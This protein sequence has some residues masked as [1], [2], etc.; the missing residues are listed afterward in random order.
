MSQRVLAFYASVL[1]FNVCDSSAQDV[2]AVEKSSEQ[3]RQ[4]LEDSVLQQVV[5]TGSRLT[6]PGLTAPTPVSVLSAE[7]LQQLNPG[8]ILDALNQ[9][10]VLK[11]SSSTSGGRGGGASRRGQNTPDLRGLGPQETLVLLDGRRMVPRNGDGYVDTNVIPTSLVS[12]VE[13]VTGGASAAYGAD[14]VAGV[15]NFILNED[16]KGIRTSIHAQESERG[17]QTQYNAG[18]A[19]GGRFADGRANL[20]LGIDATKIE[21]TGNIYTNPW[22][23]NEAG[24]IVLGNNR[25]AGLPSQVMSPNVEYSQFTPGGLILSGGTLVGTAFGR[26]GNL[27]QFQGGAL[28]G[29]ALMIGPGNY[30]NGPSSVLNLSIPLERFAG[31]TKLTYELAD[32]TKAW[33]QAGYNYAASTG[34][35]ILNHTTNS[36]IVD[37]DNPYLPG[38]LREAMVSEGLQTFRM[39]RVN[40]DAGAIDSD[41]Y[42]HGYTVAGGLD[43]GFGGD[44]YWDASVQHN[45][46]DWKN[47]ARGAMRPANFFASLYAIRSPSGDI[48]CGPL[49]LNPMLTAAQRTIVDPGCVPADPFGANSI[50]AEAA[51]YI[52]G[53]SQYVHSTYT[54]D[55]VEASL[56]GSPF[57]LW[58]GPVSVAAGASWRREEM[59]Y[60]VDTGSSSNG[61]YHVGNFAP[62]RATVTTKEGFA[63]IGVPLLT[64][65]SWIDSLELNG[66]VRLTDYSSSGRVTT[67]KVGLTQKSGPVLLRATRSRDIRAPNFSE[68]FSP[69]LT[70]AGTILN[71]FTGQ[72]TASVPVPVVR[73]PL[74][75]PE[76][77]DTWTAG[78]VYQ[79]T[80]DWLPG[81]AASVDYFDINV[82]GVITQLSGQAIMD[83]CF[84]GTQSF[85]D[86][87]TFDVTQAGG[88]SFVQ[89][90]YFNVSEFKTDGV[91]FEVHLPVPLPSF[92]QGELNTHVNATWVRS[93]VSDATGAPI[94]R[95]GQTVPEWT[96]SLNTTYTQGRFSGNVL[97]TAHSK[98]YYD[99]TLIGPDSRG[100]S[101][102][103]SNSINKNTFPSI[104][105]VTLGAK[106][107]VLQPT[108]GGSLDLFGTISNALDKELPYMAALSNGGAPGLYDFFG[109]TYKIGARYS[110]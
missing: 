33:L 11:N 81:F 84:A 60:R 27:Y 55:I 20:I 14:A 76:E 107:T 69:G 68:A 103:L 73:N 16:I 109:R 1:A 78:I 17:E 66:A 23:R 25:A 38:A 47:T 94:D 87:I 24:V 82:D 22:T 72:S 80:I 106:Y 58:A 74:I 64:D 86:R 71:R 62:Y 37:R 39:G 12:R 97:V 6:S 49:G 101:P 75:Q 98:I 90:G 43:G 40:T 96:W 85:C 89:T 65:K 35:S 41:N 95:A 110:F 100:Y 8:T 92:V 13:I 51:A 5:V 53:S 91:D 105:Y 102:S 63:E 57:S 10:P 48:I 31:L 2:S 79:P 4:Q 67:W 45:V 56:S 88:I 46:S 70:V 50:S 30:G 99:R 18:L 93:L 52:R 54:Q 21:G 36:I 77:A 15:V 9:L 7:S 28:T 3:Q 104:A 32:S 44:W 34:L 61:A 108:V 29:G 26:D 59:N 42:T 83:R 19:A